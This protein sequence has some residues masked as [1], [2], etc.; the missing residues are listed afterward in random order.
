MK[1]YFNNNFSLKTKC[2]TNNYFIDFLIMSLL[3]NAELSKG[4]PPCKCLVNSA[5]DLFHIDQ[6]F[7]DSVVKV[8]HDF[9]SSLPKAGKPQSG[10]EWTLLAC[11]VEATAGSI[12]DNS[13]QKLKVVALGTGT[14]CIG[15][16][17]M[18]KEGDIVNDSHAEVIAR[19]A[20]LRYLY[21]NID[22][23]QKEDE[24]S[25]FIFLPVCG[26]FRLKPK[27]SFHFYTSHTPCGDA[28]IFPKAEDVDVGDCVSPCN[29]VLQEQERCQMPSSYNFS[30]FKTEEKNVKRNHD[31]LCRNDFDELV[32][33]KKQKVDIHRTGAKCVPGESKQDPRA[34][35][36]GYHI[37]GAIRTKPGRGDPTLSV[38]CS[39]KLMRW[40]SVGIQGALLSQLLSSPIY[41]ESIIVDGGCPYSE[42][43]LKRAVLDRVSW[44]GN[45]FSQHGCLR[46]I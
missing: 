38:S 4:E 39:D 37:L 2:V 3:S 46:L 13:N 7:A 28:S 1:E 32:T 30:E 36:L 23:A 35:G 9:Y 45:I 20:F 8:S 14:K 6:C 33:V 34:P 40:N 26:H 15:Q 43:A 10:Q 21:H 27:V 31:N 25:I 44:L 24:S 5:R 11:I 17:K 16:G 19:R 41:M 22:L 12:N 29:D 42:V 18:S